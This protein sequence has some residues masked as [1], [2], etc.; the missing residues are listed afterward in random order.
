MEEAGLNR[1]ALDGGSE[2][3]PTKLFDDDIENYI[4]A[5]DFAAM[6]QNHLV[7]G[8]EPVPPFYGAEFCDVNTIGGFANW[9]QDWSYTKCPD[10]GRS[11]KYL[12][13]IQ[14]DTV[15]EGAEGT[16]FIEFCSDCHI[17]SMQHQQ[18]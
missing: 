8:T 16:L 15:L 1:F 3:I 10:C 17:V 5:E 9:V 2:V 4:R 18:T 7:L 11:M 14:W 6:T 13:Q 12:A